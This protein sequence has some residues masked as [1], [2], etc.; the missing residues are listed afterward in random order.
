M[1]KAGHKVPT[2]VIAEQTGLKDWQVRREV[3]KGTLNPRSMT[4]VIC[5]VAALILLREARK[6]N[7]RKTP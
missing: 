6:A 3:R 5:Y 4:S 2:R 1:P 7:Q